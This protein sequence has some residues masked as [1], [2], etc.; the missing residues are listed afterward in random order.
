MANADI[1]APLSSDLKGIQIDGQ[2]QYKGPAAQ[3]EAL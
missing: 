3:G 1:G 2:F